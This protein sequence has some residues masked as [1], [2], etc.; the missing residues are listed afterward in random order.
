[1]SHF[2]AIYDVHFG[3][4]WRALRRLGVRAEDAGDSAQVVF[5]VAF[6]RLNDFEGRSKLDTFRAAGKRTV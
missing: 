3:F 6:A 1:M 2:R 4:V 5:L